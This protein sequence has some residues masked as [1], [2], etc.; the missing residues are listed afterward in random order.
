MIQL[1]QRWVITQTICLRKL[2]LTMLA[3]TLQAKLD[4]YIVDKTI[5]FDVRRVVYSDKH[6]QKGPRL[7]SISKQ[8]SCS[9]VKTWS[10]EI[11]VFLP[12]SSL[13]FV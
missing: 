10:W 3:I 6:S 7:I 11:D 13:S 5:K 8:S 4:S 9:P 1:L 12:G 2:L